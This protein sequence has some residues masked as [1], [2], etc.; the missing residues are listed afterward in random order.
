L[1]DNVY[2][3]ENSDNH[4]VN[5]G[6][7]KEKKEDEKEDEKKSL[8]VRLRVNLEPKEKLAAPAKQYPIVSTIV[9]LANSDEILRLESMDN[10]LRLRDLGSSMSR[11]RIRLLKLRSE[12]IRE[13]RIALGAEVER[14]K[15]LLTDEELEALRA[16]EKKLIN[17]SEYLTYHTQKTI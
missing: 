1:R 15:K 2:T 12:E 6:K 4:T 3:V 5:E 13:E 8:I 11:M 16:R 10:D 14:L 9:R 7:G 17:M